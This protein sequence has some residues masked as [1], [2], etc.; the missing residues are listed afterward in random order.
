MRKL[1][2]IGTLL[3][4]LGFS[5]L[6]N[7]ALI[8]N[9]NGLIYDTDLNITWYDAVPVYYERWQEA[10]NWADVLTVGGVTGWRLPTTPGT[11]EGYTSEG[12]MGHLY[13][14]ELHNTGGH[15]TNREPFTNLQSFT[16]WTGTPYG[17]DNAWDFNFSDGV[18]D[19]L[20]TASY[21][22]AVHDGNVGAV[23]IP[24]AILLFAPGLAGIAL[25]RRRFKKS[26]CKGGNIL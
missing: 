1:F 7:A 23:P 17:L 6:T 15:F 12:E 10:N 13:Y 26:I 4:V 20:H 19:L 18:Q 11:V 22:L 5:I 24:G 3:T 2:F 8:D 21:A 14:T 9:G 25:L 16:Y